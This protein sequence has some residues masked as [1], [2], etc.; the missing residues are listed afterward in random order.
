MI[1][2]WQAKDYALWFLWHLQLFSL[3]GTMTAASSPVYTEILAWVNLSVLD[4]QVLSPD[5]L[6]KPG[7]FF[8]YLSFCTY[9][10]IWTLISQ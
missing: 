4:F 5:C 10:P 9:S 7:L 2:V 8:Y 1:V 3:V 6:S